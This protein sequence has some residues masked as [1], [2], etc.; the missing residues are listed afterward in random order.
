MDNKAHK[1]ALESRRGQARAGPLPL[2]ELAYHVFETNVLKQIRLRCKCKLLALLN[3]VFFFKE[4][5]PVK[6]SC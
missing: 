3:L 6:I 1:Q 2:D 4:T 5:Y